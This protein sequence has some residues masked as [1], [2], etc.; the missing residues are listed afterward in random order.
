MAYYDSRVESKAHHICQMIHEETGFPASDKLRSDVFLTTRATAAYWK[1]AFDRE[2]K[3]QSTYKLNELKRGI[4]RLRPNSHEDIIE[5]FTAV[6][7]GE[8]VQ[9]MVPF[10]SPL[11]EGR[12][13]W[14]TKFTQKQ[15]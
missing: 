7:N 12:L 3:L 5:L 2:L 6:M 15:T 14:V 11:R 8:S 1:N 13:L 9:T 10:D 4:D